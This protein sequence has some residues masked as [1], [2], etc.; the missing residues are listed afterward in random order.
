M[1]TVMT[2]TSDSWHW[3][4]AL[5]VGI[6]AI[7][8]DH[9]RLFQLFYEAHLVGQEDDSELLYKLASELILYTESH[10][11]REEVVMTAS[12]YPN[13]KEHFSTHN[14]IIKQLQNTLLKIVDGKQSIAEFILFFKDWFVDHI[15]KTDREFVQYTKGFEQEIEQAL[16]DAGPLSIPKQINIY[17]VDDEQ[18]QVDMMVEMIDIAGFSATGFISAETFVE[19]EIT[20]NDIVLL[21][22]NMP[23][24]DGIEVMRLLHARECLP[25]YLLISGFDERV[26]HSAKQFADA[27]NITVAKTFTKPLNTRSFIECINQIHGENKLII[28]KRSNKQDSQI[29]SELDAQSPLSRSELIAAIEQHQLVLFYQPQID[30][31]TG[32]LHGFEALVRLQH[33]E[34]GLVFP[35]QFINLAEQYNLISSLTDE[36]IHLATEDYLSF[37]N[38]GIEPKISINISAQDLLDLSM[39]ERFTSIL[40]AKNISTNA[41]TIELTESAVLS[42][43]SDSLDILNRLRMKGFPLSIDDFGTGN[44]SLVQLYQ[45]PFTELKIDQ[46]FIMRMMKDDEAMSIVKICILLAKEL[47]MDTVA[48][49]VETQ[50][51]WDELKVLGCD[52]AQGYH[53]SKPI[54]LEKCCEWI[55]NNK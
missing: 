5:S 40:E 29:T 52:I 8:D 11:K 53:I 24:M 48:E 54:P 27:K 43:V 19:Q 16:I 41:I 45:A 38:A 51:I 44:S 20:N 37:R 31:K 34:R 30:I 55:A 35:D 2:E 1:E 22:L 50:Q 39:P 25:T 12:N 6:S 14:A 9:K 32:K 7:D 33:P 23:N 15:K 28:D 18:Q 4:P 47:K 46:H 42:S 26:L 36:V 3:T 17:V 13:C 49:G 10:F 21:D